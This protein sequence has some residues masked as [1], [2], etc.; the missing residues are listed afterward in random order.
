MTENIAVLIVDD[1]VEVGNFFRYLLAPKQYRVKT[2]TTVRQAIS[3]IDQEE[4][5]LVLA[6]LKL[7]DGDGLTILKHTKEKQPACG[8]I[9]MTGFSTVQTAVEAIKLGAYDYIDKPFE[10]INQLEKLIDEALKNCLGAN[11]PACPIEDWVDTLTDLGYMVGQSPKM[12]QLLALAAKIAKKPLTVLLQGETGTGKEMLARFIHARSARAS[13]TFIPIN[14]AALTDNLLESELFGHEKGA[15]TGAHTQRRGMFEIAD[16][17]TLFLDEIGEASLSTQAKLLRVL[18]NGE[19]VRL[20]GEKS[21][22]TDVRIVTATNVNLDQAVAENRFRMDLLFRLDVIKL[23][24][25]PLRERSEDIPLF[26]EFFAAKTTAGMQKDTVT[27]HPEALAALLTYSWPGNV[28]ELANVVSQAAAL[29]DGGMI[30]LKDLPSKLVAPSG[31]D[32]AANPPAAGAANFGGTVI[33]AGTANSAAI[34][35]PN[36]NHLDR[37][38]S[39]TLSRLVDELDLSGGLDLPEIAE[40]LKD[41]KTKLS[42]RLIEKALR[43]TLGDRKAVSELLNINSRTLRYLL[44]EKNRSL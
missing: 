4:F 15:F 30:R 31:E 1:E 14:C 21:L 5:T 36:L 3:L 43:E 33:A 6:D 35:D 11:S 16:K 37:V 22:R 40:R 32:A 38:L 41:F 25:P 26:A 29:C 39:E 27:F 7:P 24:I 8:V 34:P 44:K 18:E 10:D 17:G 23:Q 12:V 20:G 2:A 9:I 28:R 13:Q 42:V 19:Y